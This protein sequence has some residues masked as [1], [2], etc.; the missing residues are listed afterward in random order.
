MSMSASAEPTGLGAPEGAEPHPRLGASPAIPSA[1]Y[2]IMGSS[3]EYSD[4]YER[5]IGFVTSEAAAKAVVEQA[6]AEKALPDPMPYP[7]HE[8]THAWVLPDGTLYDEGDGGFWARPPTGAKW[9]RRSDADEIEARQEAAREAWRQARID[10]GRIDPDGSMDSY[11]FEVAP[12]L[13]PASRIEA[14]SD[15]TPQS[16]PA[17]RARA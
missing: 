10:A 7:P 11:Y 3:G 6:E 2:V 12:A 15:G 1:V 17:R 14:R 9:T 4:R 13:S 8:R 16:G 5:V